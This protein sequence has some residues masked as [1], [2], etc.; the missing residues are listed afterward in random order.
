L[1]NWQH[2]YSVGA[3]AAGYAE[4]GDFANA[5]K[6]QE[7]FLRLCSEGDKK[8]W[9]HLLELYKSGKRFQEQRQEFRFG[10]AVGE[11]HASAACA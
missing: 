1:S 11:M 4:S 7:A 3:L 6:W 10:R 5:V 2:A 8:K 9:G